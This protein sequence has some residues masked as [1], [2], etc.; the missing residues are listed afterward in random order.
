MDMIEKKDVEKLLKNV[1]LV[2][3]KMG[4]GNLNSIKVITVISELSR[5]LYV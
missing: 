3:T 2:C 1:K 5:N 4:F